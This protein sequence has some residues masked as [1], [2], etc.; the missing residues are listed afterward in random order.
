VFR[1]CRP[2]EALGYSRLFMLTTPCL[3]RHTKGVFG[4]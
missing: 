3:I 4:E 1:L 2:P